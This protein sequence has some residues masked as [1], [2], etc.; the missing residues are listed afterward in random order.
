MLAGRVLRSATMQPCLAVQLKS[1][2][3]GVGN[4]F[5]TARV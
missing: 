1:S 2:R 4:A 5:A 3:R